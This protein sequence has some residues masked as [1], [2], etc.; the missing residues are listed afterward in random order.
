MLLL[1]PTAISSAAHHG[2]SKCLAQMNQ[3]LQPHAHQVL[4]S[5]TN[6]SKGNINKQTTGLSDSMMLMESSC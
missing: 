4:L 5:F 3:Q 2:N 6:R 1:C